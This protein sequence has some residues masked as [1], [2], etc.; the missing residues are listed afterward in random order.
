MRILAGLT[1]LLFIISCSDKD[2]MPK[3]IIRMKPMQQIVWDMLQ[4]DEVAFQRKITDSTLNLKTASF[5]LYDT[6]FAIHKVSRESF[7][8][9]YEYYQRRPS[10]YKKLMTGVKNIGDAQRKAR[11]TPAS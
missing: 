4:A 8:K 10:L 5:H 1:F 2:E 7:Y 3:E 9:S 11:Q 6:V